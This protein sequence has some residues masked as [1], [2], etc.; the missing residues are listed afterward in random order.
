MEIE[1]LVIGIQCIVGIHCWIIV[2]YI[3]QGWNSEGMSFFYFLPCTFQAYLM[4]STDFVNFFFSFFLFGF[5][6]LNYHSTHSVL[7]VSTS[8]FPRF[9]FSRFPFYTNVY[10]FSHILCDSYICDS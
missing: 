4:E 7:F 9:K 10:V 8:T 3:L 5:S 6:Y 1:Y 2:L